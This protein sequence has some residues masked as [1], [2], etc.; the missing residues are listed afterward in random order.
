MTTKFVSNKLLRSVPVEIAFNREISNNQ[1]RLT[2]PRRL[3][4]DDSHYFV[5]RTDVV[6]APFD[7]LIFKSAPVE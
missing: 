2:L 4:T 3:R 5:L 6:H 1:D 7:H